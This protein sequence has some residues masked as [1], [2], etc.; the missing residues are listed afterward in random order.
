MK[1]IMAAIKSNSKIFH[2]HKML[3]TSYLFNILFGYLAKISECWYQYILN[4]Y[5]G[6]HVKK[7]AFILKVVPV[8][9]FNKILKMLKRGLNNI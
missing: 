7:Q 5:I 2:N 9:L 8:N 1:L 4:I 3:I 6:G